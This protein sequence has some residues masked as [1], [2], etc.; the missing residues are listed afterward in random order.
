MAVDRVGAIL[1]DDEAVKRLRQEV[2]GIL[3]HCKS[4]AAVC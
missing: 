3:S 1:E 2:I 4:D